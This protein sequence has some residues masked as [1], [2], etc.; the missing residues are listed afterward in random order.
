MTLRGMVEENVYYGLDRDT[1][2]DIGDSP[3]AEPCEEKGREEPGALASGTKR[4]R[5]GQNGWVIWGKGSY[6]ERRA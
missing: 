1:G 5:G 3:G 4:G 6:G 2:R